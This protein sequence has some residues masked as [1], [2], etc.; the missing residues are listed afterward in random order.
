MTDFLNKDQFNSIKHYE[1]DLLKAD[2]AQCVSIYKEILPLFRSLVNMEMGEDYLLRKRKG[3]ALCKI[4][5]T[6]TGESTAGFF[7]LSGFKLMNEEN[8]RPFFAIK[9]VAYADQHIRGKNFTARFYVKEVAKFMCQNLLS[10][11]YALEIAAHYPS[12]VAAHANVHEVYPDVNG[13]IPS[14]YAKVFDMAKSNEMFEKYIT[15]PFEDPYLCAVQFDTYDAK[16]DTRK[17]DE[18]ISRN[19]YAKRFKETGAGD[20]NKGYLLLSPM[21]FKNISISIFRTVFNT[22]KK[23]LI[24]R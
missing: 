15:F 23:K 1:Y 2:E 13:Y 11:I 20:I 7:I 18:K 16:E 22:F 8:N 14:K 9:Y 3:T 4:R 5:V 19:K 24:K 6:K 17:W 12:Y 10:K 21:T